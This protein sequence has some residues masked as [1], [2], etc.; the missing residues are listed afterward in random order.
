MFYERRREEHNRQQRQRVNY[1][2]DRRLCSRTYIRGRPRVWPLTLTLTVV[3]DLTFAVEVG[4]VLAALMFIRKVS[5]TTTVSPVTKDDVADSRVHVLQGKDLPDY[6]IVYRIPELARF[7][8]YLLKRTES[9]IEE[10]VL[11]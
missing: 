11:S 8:S 3:T 10:K 2:C 4:M 1:P 7:S 9:R 5:R 6:A